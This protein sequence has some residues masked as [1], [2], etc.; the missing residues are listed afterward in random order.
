MH[1]LN[2][3]YVVRVYVFVSVCGVC[4]LIVFQS[5]MGEAPT[6]VPLLLALEVENLPWL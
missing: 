2:F 5:S 4:S 3:E 1:P 6:F